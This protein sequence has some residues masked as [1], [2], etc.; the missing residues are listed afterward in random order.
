MALSA[1]RDSGGDRRLHPRFRAAK[2]VFALLRNRREKVGQVFDISRGGLS[3]RY[4]QEDM[5]QDGA[6][7]IDLFSPRAKVLLE[8]VPVRTVSD[9]AVD[10][11]IPYST[12]PVRQRAVQ[13][14][15]VKPTQQRLLDHLIK[16]HT[17]STAS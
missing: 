12:I 16:H 14:L 15:E 4:I 11:D 7:S 13:F 3:F 2:D 5:L 9:I 1:S 10:Q 6:D 8:K 17:V